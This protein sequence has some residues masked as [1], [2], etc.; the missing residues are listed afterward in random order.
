MCHFKGKGWPQCAGHVPRQLDR[1]SVTRRLSWDEEALL[2]SI[3]LY[4]RKRSPASLQ[5]I[6]QMAAAVRLQPGGA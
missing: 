2:R 1:K 5:Q 6:R 4:V 3:I